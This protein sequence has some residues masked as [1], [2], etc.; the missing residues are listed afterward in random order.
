MS[1]GLDYLPALIDVKTDTDKLLGKDI[2]T[3]IN[4]FRYKNGKWIDLHPSVINPRYDFLKKVP[5]ESKLTK[6]LDKL[7]VV[8]M[9]IFLTSM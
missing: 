1:E 4:V 9:P 3:N 2:L 8:S 6:E 5:E 7:L